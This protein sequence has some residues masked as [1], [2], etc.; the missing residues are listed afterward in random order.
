MY[1]KHTAKW[2]LLHNIIPGANENVLCHMISKFISYRSYSTRLASV[3]FQRVL[4][5]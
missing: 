4:I 1:Y 2:R 5:Y 3:L